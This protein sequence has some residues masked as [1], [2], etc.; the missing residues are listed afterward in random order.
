MKIE[1]KS[2]RATSGSL[3][4][5]AYKIIGKHLFLWYT[6]DMKTEAWVTKEFHSNRLTNEFKSIERQLVKAWH[7][8]TPNIF[9]AVS[10]EEPM[11]DANKM[12]I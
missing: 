11:A 1:V 9:I 2:T 6:L 4:N 8:S 12:R 7:G 5:G 3:T 10:N